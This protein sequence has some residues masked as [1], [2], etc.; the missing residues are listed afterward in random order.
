MNGSS[1]DDSQGIGLVVAVLMAALSPSAAFAANAPPAPTVSKDDRAKGMAAAPGLIQ[2]GHID[3]QLADA[4]KLGDNV[5]PKTKLKS[6]L[7]ELACAGNEGVVVVQS[8]ADPPLVFT[9]LEASQPRPEGKPNPTTLQVSSPPRLE[10]EAAIVLLAD[11]LED[12]RGG[13]VAEGRTCWA[14]QG[15]PDLAR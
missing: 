9:C 6:I 4:R 14:V 15:T 1:L 8:G 2:A 3:C 13:R 11:Q 10:D 5:D 7:Y 12:R